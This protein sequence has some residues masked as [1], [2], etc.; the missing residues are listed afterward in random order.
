MNSKTALGQLTIRLLVHFSYFPP[1]SILNCAPLHRY[2]DFHNPCY[3]PRPNN[4]PT[5][6]ELVDGALSDVSMP[7]L[8]SEGVVGHTPIEAVSIAGD[9]LQSKASHTQTILE[10]LQL[11][12]AHPG[13]GDSRGYRQNERVYR[14]SA[15]DIEVDCDWWALCRGQHDRGGCIGSARQQ[16]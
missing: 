6:P 12:P 10:H 7:F 4:P 15:V 1:K 14:R 8:V 16:D 11:R 5:H 9:V 13:G 3:L 2:R